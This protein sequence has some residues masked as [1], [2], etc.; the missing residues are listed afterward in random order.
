MLKRI[1]FVLL[2]LSLASFAFST[3]YIIDNYNFVF[4][5]NTDASVVYSKLKLEDNL[6]F[7]S[8]EALQAFV[9]SKEQEIANWD[10]FNGTESYVVEVGDSSGD[11][12]EVMASTDVSADEKH[13]TA[14]FEIN[15]KS[16]LFIF[17]VPKYDSNT[18][19]SLGVGVASEN[20]AGKLAHF[21]SQVIVEQTDKT[22]EHAKY[23]LELFINRFPISYFHMDNTITILYEGANNNTTINFATTLYDIKLG[24][25][26]TFRLDTG[27]KFKPTETDPIATDE[28][29]YSATFDNLLESW[30]G[31]TFTQGNSYHSETNN[32]ETNFQLTYHG[33]KIKEQPLELS[34]SAHNNGLSAF[35]SWSYSQLNKEIDGNQDFRKGMSLALYASRTMPFNNLL[36]ASS[37]YATL[38]FKYFPYANDWINPSMRVCAIVSQNPT[39]Y[40]TT[41]A[42]SASNDYLL[43]QYLRGLQDNN[44]YSKQLYTAIITLNLDFMT[45]N[46]DL[47]TLAR[48]YIDPCVDAAILFRE[49]QEPKLLYTFGV[50]LL[51]IM[52][53][54]TSYPIRVSFGFNS[55]L[56][57][58]IYAGIYYYY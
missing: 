58:E 10:I 1:I 45:R 22:F 46:V 25:T 32:L 4:H 50:E 29:S 19:I 30:G 49:G 55:E 18:G 27:L 44:A 40:L 47:G 37:Q 31:F 42:E 53:E 3:T 21:F 15:D 57:Y 26:V 17:P 33:I 8:Y 23:S 51:G 5:E 56:E 11:S 48:T 16:P 41:D 39:H 35:I 6:S 36:E 13:Y 12:T 52:C 24:D 28:L 43:A 54:H 14:V 34:L 2:L 9:R 7:E 38:T 20:F